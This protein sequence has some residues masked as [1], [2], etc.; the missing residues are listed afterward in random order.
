[1][2][3]TK[4]QQSFESFDQLI[5]KVRKSSNTIR[6]K[7]TLFEYM[8]QVYLKTVGREKFSHVWMLKDVPDSIYVSY[9]HKYYHISHVDRGVDLVAQIADTGELVAV[10][11][12]FYNQNDVISKP[13]IDSFVAELGQNCY[14]QGIWFTSQHR[15]NGNARA[16]MSHT[17]KQIST[18][19]LDRLEHANIDWSNFDLVHL[20]LNKN[21]DLRLNK[22]K[23][24]LRPYQ[25]VAKDKAVR[26]YRRCYKDGDNFY[27]RGK[28]IMAPGTGK[29]YTSLNIAEALQY[30][31]H[32]KDFYVLYLVPSI[33]LLTQ[34]LFSWGRDVNDDIDMV[35]FAVTSDNKATKSDDVD[36]VF[37]PYPATTNADNLVRYYKRNPVKSSHKRMFVIFS[38]YQSI[39]VIHQAQ[40][41]TGIRKS[42]IP[43]FD[44]IVSDEAH[45]TA[46]YHKKG[47]PGYFSK[48]HS[49]KNVRSQLRLYQ[50]ATPKIYGEK[51][52]RKGK[53]ESV[54]IASM[55]DKKIYG[56]EIF[57]YSFGQAV[58]SGWLTDYKVVVLTISK[59]YANE[60]MQKLFSSNSASAGIPIN[61]YGKILGTINAMLKRK[62]FSNEVSG[63]PMK[64][65]IAFAS[66]NDNT[67]VS[68]KDRNSVGAKQI[69]QEA[70]SIISAKNK[71]QNGNGYNI[72]FKA[73]NG[74]MN[75]MQREHWIHWL[76]NTKI[77]HNEAR[78]LSNVRFLGEGIDVP[79]LD[80]VIFFAPKQSEIDIAQAIGRVMRRFIDPETGKRKQWGYIILPI[81]VPNG[82]NPSAILRNSN[83]DYIWKVLNIIRSTDKRFD[84]EINSLKFNS[85]KHNN[86]TQLHNFDLIGENSSPEKNLNEDSYNEEPKKYKDNKPVVHQTSLP[87]DWDKLQSAIYGEIV[88]HVG[89]RHYLEDWSDNIRNIAKDYVGWIGNKVALNNSFRKSFNNYLN[90]LKHNINDSI[91]PDQA[92]NMIAQHIITEPVFD[93]LF[94]HNNFANNPVSKAMNYIVQK[95]NSIGFQKKQKSLKSFYDSVKIRAQ[96]IDDLSHKQEFIRSL[97]GEFFNKSFGE[98]TSRLG[99][100]FTPV[101]IVDFIIHSV[102]Y[103]LRH[104]FHGDNLSSKGVHILDPFVG[105]GTFITET[106]NYFKK[107]R[108]NHK[109][110]N[111]DIIRNYNKEL[112]CNEIVLLSYYIAAI[113]IESVFNEIIGQIEYQEFPGIV[114]TDTFNSYKHKSLL[115]RDMFSGNDKRAVDEENTPIT[116]I[117]SNPP[118][119]KGKSSDNNNK[120]VHYPKLENEIKKTYVHESRYPGNTK[121]YNRYIEAIRWA[122]DHI[123]EN[124]VIGI[125]TNAVFLDSPSTD[126]IRKCLHKEFNYIYIYNLKGNQ[127]LVGKERQKGG[128]PVFGANGFGSGSKNPIAISILI[129]KANSNEHKIFYKDIGDYLKRT[130]KFARLKKNYSIG[131]I[132]WKEIH[133]SKNGDWI[134]KSNNKYETY[135][136]LSSKKKYAPSIFGYCSPGS[137]SY[138][139]P[140]LYGFSYDAVYHHA[141]TLIKHYNHERKEYAEHNNY[142]INENHK[143]IDLSSRLRNKLKRNKP[144][145][146]HPNH[147]IRSLY[148]P[149]T[150]KYFYYDKDVVDRPTVYYDKLGKDN[151]VIFTTGKNSTRP[152]SAIATNLVPDQGVGSSGKGF[153]RYDES[154]P[155]NTLFKLH[156]KDNIN[157]SFADKLGL[158]TDDTFYYVY[159]ILNSP[160]YKHV[161]KNNLRYDY[162]AR[163]PVVKNIKPFITIGKKLLKLHVNYENVTPY[164]KVPN[165]GLKVLY[166]PKDVHYNVVH[167]MEYGKKLVDGKNEKDRSVIVFNPFITIENI[168]KRAYKFQINGQPA[169]EWIREQYHLTKDTKTGSGIVDDPNKYSKDSKY[170]FKLL[171]KVITVSVKTVDLVNKLPKMQIINFDWRKN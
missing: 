40:N 147:I 90:S 127:R 4:S 17:S 139:D 69:A 105:T 71:L 83:Y 163:I 146:F 167:M 122:S 67:A 28:L 157:K 117:M 101:D 130:Q 68:S 14:D 104:Y 154:I 144:I 54:V 93:A 138:R 31:E 50:T 57:N 131:N 62:S 118:Y 109:I 72:K 74:G 99:I 84:A 89:N 53:E 30:D 134:N 48:V 135:I 13:A 47:Q 25:K 81:V 37:K 87:L 153:M 152:F 75:A 92:I 77:P 21:K 129:K 140:W 32:K 3:R 170:I 136:P 59:K 158:T 43:D 5:D 108:D 142:K 168:P 63:L 44:L 16:M 161:Y 34:T 151:C 7:G 150:K 91:Q 20:D 27:S 102:D 79:N 100:V 166:N 132:N 42:T 141:E 23:R 97:Y 10:Q 36:N 112:H 115:D 61:D 52:R 107:L 78:V 6:D 22:K 113:N 45:R 126:G 125:V 65:A 51:A 39:D 121:L 149:F 70:N 26:Y 49:N 9:K 169:I 29:T 103:A 162:S 148:R 96:N 116:V 145:K 98:T 66:V 111:T 137:K 55:N 85:K 18:V 143:Y 110:S 88:R 24:G 60:D 15:A 1:M 73:V 46:V 114:L 165:N 82:A 160:E 86:R 94:N 76:S 120:D 124:G 95:M 58:D 156:K 119:S 11:A 35:K 8:A 159:G 155:S 128:E 41:I 133:P 33:Q 38:T 123:H 80:A 164:N 2:A 64:R 171:M 19:G 12:K 56:N 106:L